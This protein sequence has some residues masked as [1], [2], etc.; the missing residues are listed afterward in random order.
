MIW[1]KEKEDI[2]ELIIL[3]IYKIR[4]KN[5]MKEMMIIF[6]TTIQ[7]HCIDQLLNIIFKR[8]QKNQLSFIKL[9][10]THRTLYSNQKLYRKL[11]NTS[12]MK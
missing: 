6:K 11:L 5:T 7:F 9:F 10:K 12:G 4:L 8:D 1:R 2:L 3:R